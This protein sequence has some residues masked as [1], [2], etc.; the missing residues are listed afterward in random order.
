MKFLLMGDRHNSEQKPQSRI[1]DF[2]ETQK[3]KDEEII[4]IAK[5][6]NVAAIIQAGD[7]WT[8]SDYKIKN[9][10]IPEIIKRWTNPL[11]PKDSI[12]MLGIA[13]NHDL[14][15]GNIRSLPNTTLGLTA[16][17]GYQRLV[18]K[19]NPVIF[20]LENGKTVAITGTNY[21]VHMDKPEYIDD[22]IVDNKL[23]DYHIHVVHGM[24]SPKNLGKIIR[25]TT[26]D[27][28]KNTKADITF[29]G[30]DHIGFD[31]VCYD[32]KYF[33]NPGAIVR[34]KNDVKELSRTVK[35]VILTI[36]DSGISLEEVP[37]KSALDASFVLSREVV[38]QKKLKDA[39]AEKMK[40][41]IKSLEITKNTRFSEILEDVFNKEDV[42]EDIMNDLRKKIAEKELLN[43]S[44][45]KVPTDVT[46]ESINLENFQS[47]ENTTIKLSKG[48]NVLLGESRQGKTAL[49]R[50]FR[51]VLE[52]KPTGNSM[53]RHGA[54]KC[55]VTIKLINGTY[56][57]RFISKKENGYRIILPDGT[58]QEG[59]THMVGLVQSICGFNDM[60]VT[61]GL[62]MPINFLRQGQGWYLIDD[63]VSSTE[64][65]R[66]LGSLQNTQSA[67]SIVKDLDK[68]NSQ[69][70][71][72]IKN[73]NVQIDKTL[74]DVTKLTSE[75]E[76]MEK[77][78]LLLE[79]MLLKERILTYLSL[80]SEHKEKSRQADYLSDAYSKILQ[81]NYL[82]QIKILKEKSEL[83]ASETNRVLK[84]RVALADAS[85]KIN[86]CDLVINNSAKIT[87]IKKLLEKHIL[88]E[89]NVSV[90]KKETRR[91]KQISNM[92]AGLSGCKESLIPEIKKL[93]EKDS[94]IRDSI[95]AY[96]KHVKTTKAADRLIS[97]SNGVLTADKTIS[98]LNKLLES[99]TTIFTELK[100]CEKLKQEV[101]ASEKKISELNNQENNYRELKAQALK[102]AKICP[103]CS[104]II[105][106]SVTNNILGGCSHE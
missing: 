101:L 103:I 89:D 57:T 94:I 86:H 81:S 106:D 78:K 14:I 23:G 96:N 28:I 77:I 31:T 102:D 47:H 88:I 92:L 93:I 85:K 20:T 10:F 97:A 29:C 80:K 2:Y 13:G 12:P 17:L 51:W 105:T 39:A 83:I 79:K 33:I 21:H 55:S 16:A 66:I 53:V 34:L 59:N 43:N 40:S 45:L 50:A 54:D 38:E 35:V 74:E 87:S 68:E 7:F 26:I 48:F 90:F 71:T 67:D 46:V 44:F 4:S 30:H 99:K 8:D 75:R 52:N 62:S 41:E 32:G 104:Q 1:D 70:T 72:N 56:I 42:S 100:N 24:L 76:H 5:K 25:H 61:N 9:D 69:I 6:Y 73:N 37:L 3:A 11:N 60:Q 22:Y 36:D 27:A 84:E 65:A 15:G 64:R 98:Q 18:T 91:Q 82:S 58:V 95:I 63:N 19:D 49:M